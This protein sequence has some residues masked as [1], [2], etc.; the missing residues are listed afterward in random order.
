MA[1]EIVEHDP[2]DPQKIYDELIKRCKGAKSWEIRCIID[3]KWVG[4][5]PFEIYIEDGIFY[6]RVV[7]PTLKEAYIIVANKLPVIKFLDYKK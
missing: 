1:N 3:E 7:A 2:F 5:A 4:L 6:C